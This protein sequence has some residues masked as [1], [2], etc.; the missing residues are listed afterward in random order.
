MARSTDSASSSSDNEAHATEAPRSPSEHTS[1][2]P[3][4][5]PTHTEDDPQ[6]KERGRHP[7]P[8][9]GSRN[10]STMIVPRTSTQIEDVE[11]S[12][13]PDDARAMSPRRNSDETDA[14][15]E[16]TRYAVRE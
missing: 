1:T 10:S 6:Q 13:S 11:D 4:V 15:E 3:D 8:K 9:M 14:M 5:S 7:R 2:A 16:A 12:F